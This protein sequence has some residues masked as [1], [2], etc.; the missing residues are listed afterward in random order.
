MARRVVVSLLIAATLVLAGVGAYSRI[1]H[2]PDVQYVEPPVFVAPAA[3]AP[4]EA[5]QFA[6]LA[7]S[8]AVAMLAACLTSYAKEATGFRATLA[9]RER[10]K[11]KVHEPESVRVMATG[12]VPGPDKKTHIRVRMIWDQGAHADAFGNQIRGSVYVEDQAPEQLVIFRP[13]AAFL[14]EFSVPYKSDLAREA[15]RYCIKDAGLYRSMLRTY[16]AWKKR[17]DAGELSVTYLGKRTVPEVGGRECF[18]MKRTCKAAEI[19]PFALDEQPPTDQKVI[20]RDGFSEVTLFID[21]E[22]RLQLGTVIRRTDGELVGE[23]FFRDVE[24]VKAEFPSDTF[25]P[26]ALRN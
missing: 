15:S 18:V 13:T 14:K 5:E 10:I 26:A 12:D 6:K 25:T 7:E 2:T 19:D 16:A 3:A 20:D 4:T 9:K 21:V 22:R 24:L 17:Q 23:Y 11:G 1:V 8:D